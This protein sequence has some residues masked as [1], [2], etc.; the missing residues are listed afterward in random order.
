[1]TIP[2]RLASPTAEV[3]SSREK[4]TVLMPTPVL[5]ISKSSC[6]T[7][8]A[9][10]SNA[11]FAVIPRHKSQKIKSPKNPIFFILVGFLSEILDMDIL[12]TANFF[13]QN[14][15]ISSEK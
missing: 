4:E 12:P 10:E 9:G 2:E 15:D 3:K 6:I 13:M 11:A 14:L 7:D 8:I 5:M 1:M